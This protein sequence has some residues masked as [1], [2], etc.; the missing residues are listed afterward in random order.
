MKLK[1]FAPILLLVS[2]IAC[3]QSTVKEMLDAGGKRLDAAE[4]KSLVPGSTLSGR[5]S[6]GSAGVEQFA[7]K[8]KEGGGLDGTFGMNNVSGS[9]EIRDPGILCMNLGTIKPCQAVYLHG[10]KYFIAGTGGK[11]DPAAD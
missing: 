7:F 2:S 1:A 4:L 5:G 10:G 9:W 11:P 8:M 3:A 6:G